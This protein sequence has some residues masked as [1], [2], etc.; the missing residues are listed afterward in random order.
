MKNNTPT[1]AT[2]GPTH[3][4]SNSKLSPNSRQG[5]TTSKRSRI[6]AFLELSRRLHQAYR[7]AYD[8]QAAEWLL[9]QNLSHVDPTMEDKRTICGQM[10]DDAQG[11]YDK[12]TKNYPNARKSWLAQQFNREY[13][14]HTFGSYFAEAPLGFLGTQASGRNNVLGTRDYQGMSRFPAKFLDTLSPSDDQVHHFRAYFIAGLAGHYGAA[15]AHRND[16]EEMG[17]SG[18]VR[19][20]DQSFKL[21][22]YFRQNPGKLNKVGE[23]IKSIICKGEEVPR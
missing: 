18:D 7:F 10:A 20:G 21:G 8:K 11:F 9:P 6:L 13:G 2:P 5:L 3:V 16:D 23:I 17:N 15:K 14:M 4:W 19:L 12:V 22:T 1:R